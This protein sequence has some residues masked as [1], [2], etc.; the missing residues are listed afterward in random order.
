MVEAG[1]IPATIAD[2]PVVQAL[3]PIFPDLRIHDDIALVENGS[4]AWA[5]RKGSP[6]LAKA[7]AS[8]P[9]ASARHYETGTQAAL[10]AA[11]SDHQ[12]W[13]INSVH[14]SSPWS[15]HLAWC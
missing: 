7:A 4:Y 14:N 15:R 10:G 13:N 3:Q 1:L 5:F 6:K 8:A 9:T 2:E 11:C 12:D